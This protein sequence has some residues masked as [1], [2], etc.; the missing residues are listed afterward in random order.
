MDDGRGRCRT[1]LG[2]QELLGAI[3]D[4]H[5]YLSLFLII[6]LFFTAVGDTG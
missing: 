3:I 2:P 5:C 6:A 4:G 1:R